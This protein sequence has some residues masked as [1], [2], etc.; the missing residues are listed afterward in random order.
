[1]PIK[2][3]IKDWKAEI[4]TIPNILS[5]LRLLLIPIYVAIY[6]NAAEIWHYYMAA[7]VLAVSCLTDMVDGI[8]ARQFNMITN[9]GKLLDPVADKATQFA[10]ILCLASRFWMM[11]LMIVVF[12]VKETFQLVACGLNLRHGKALDGALL[13]GKVCTTV[14]F[15][16]LILLVMVPAMPELSGNLMIAI[17]TVFLLIAFGD[18]VMAYYGQQSLVVDIFKKETK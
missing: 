9:L 4:L 17:D 2:E 14:L 7:A 10:M 18:Y 12:V 8:I 16:T 5:L 13:S 1:M 11:Y 15:A 6:L 3:W